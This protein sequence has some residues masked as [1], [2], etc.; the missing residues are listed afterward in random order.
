LERN[1]GIIHRF[2]LLLLFYTIYL[3][4]QTRKLVLCP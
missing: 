2:N 3:P 4:I 1:I